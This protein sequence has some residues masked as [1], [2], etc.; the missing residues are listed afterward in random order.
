MNYTL[1]LCNTEGRGTVPLIS[2]LFEFYYKNDH[3][4]D[5]F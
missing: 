1:M 4:E 5:I 2:V 3:L